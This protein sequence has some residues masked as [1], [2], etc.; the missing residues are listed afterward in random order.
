M[1]TDGGETW[2]KVL[3]IDDQHGCADLDIDVKNPNILYAAL[4][5]FERKPWTFTRGS[6]KTGVFR[7]LDGGRT[8]KQLD[9]RPARK[10]LGR[11]GVSVAPSNPN[12][13]YVV[14]ESNEGTLFRSD[15]RGDHFTR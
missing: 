13:V 1:T 15:D 12:V 14:A 4:W 10:A 11:I 9:Q 5:R 8:W 2:K 3:Y 7:S 6:E